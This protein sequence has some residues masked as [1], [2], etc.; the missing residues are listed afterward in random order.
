MISENPAREAVRRLLAIPVPDDI[1]K[2]VAVV[3]G[4]NLGSN[5][6]YGVLLMVR[7]VSL[8]RLTSKRRH[9]PVNL[10]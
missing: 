8:Q 5:A 4:V 3:Y 10:E 9:W 6:T 7:C 2:E 1:K